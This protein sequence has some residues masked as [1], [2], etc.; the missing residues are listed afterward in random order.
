MLEFDGSSVRDEQLAW[1]TTICKRTS[2]KIGSIE[3]TAVLWRNLNGH[4]IKDAKMDA[5]TWRAMIASTT[6][7]E[8]H[9]IRLVCVCAR[10]GRMV[11]VV[12]VGGS[13]P[14]QHLDT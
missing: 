12:C 10:V 4:A 13:L 14:F 6:G 7:I 1:E 3:D 9:K 8:T 11:F 2:L 5:L